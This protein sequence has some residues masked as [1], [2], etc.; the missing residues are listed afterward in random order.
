MRRNFETI[1]QHGISSKKSTID[2]P[3]EAID[4]YLQ[5]EFETQFSRLLKEELLAR[6]PN[7]QKKIKNQISSFVQQQAKNGEYVELPYYL[8]LAARKAGLGDLQKHFYTWKNGKMEVVMLPSDLNNTYALDAKKNYL[9]KTREHFSE[10]E[11][12]YIQRVETAHQQLE[13]L[14]NLGGT[15]AFLI[16]GFEDELDLPAE[17][18]VLI[19]DKYKEWNAF[20]SDILLYSAESA[21]SSDIVMKYQAFAEYFENLYRGILLSLGD[22]KMSNDVDSF[23][24]YR[25]ALSL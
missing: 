8:L 6:T 9:T 14:R 20:K 3:T 4:S 2:T 13:N 21:T 18:E 22:F 15:T 19:S 11:Q 1:D 12:V 7:H 16:D 23:A 10:Q 24:L 5:K 17:I 25:G